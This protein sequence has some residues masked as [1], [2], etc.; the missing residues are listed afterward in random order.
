MAFLCCDKFGHGW[1]FLGHDR[2]FLVATENRQ[3]QRSPGH[4]IRD[5]GLAMT[6]EVYVVT[7]KKK[8]MSRHSSLMLEGVYCHNRDLCV[9]TKN[10]Y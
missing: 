2:T 9:A 5:R 3:D 1:G 8:M 6:K 7:E 4:N 10:N